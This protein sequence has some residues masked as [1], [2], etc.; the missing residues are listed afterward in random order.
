MTVFKGTAVRL[1]FQ[2]MKKKKDKGVSSNC[3]FFLSQI[4]LL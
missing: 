2:T 1:A 4:C 3:P